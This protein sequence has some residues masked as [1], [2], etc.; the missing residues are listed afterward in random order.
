MN[1]RSVIVEL[2]VIKVVVAYA[3]FC[4]LNIISLNLHCLIIT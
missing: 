4:K 3:D 1:C 2:K